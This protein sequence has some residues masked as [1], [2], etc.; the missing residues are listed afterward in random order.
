MIND[1]ARYSIGTWDTELQ[2]YTPQHGVSCFYLSRAEL[3]QSIAQLRRL[4]YSAHRRGNTR[5][6]HDDNDWAV[7]IER[8]DGR[9]AMEI[10]EGWKR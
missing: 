2:A 8:T 10:L 7:L 4:G 3:R 1:I 5:D 9:T 6:G